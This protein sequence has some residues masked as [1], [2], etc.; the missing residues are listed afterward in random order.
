MVTFISYTAFTFALWVHL[1]TLNKNTFIH[2]VFDFIWRYDQR[3]G[4]I[5]DSAWL[6]DATARQLSPRAVWHHDVLLEAPAWGQTHIWLH[7]ECSGWLLHRYRSTVPTSAIVMTIQT[8]IFKTNTF[9]IGSTLLLKLL[10]TSRFL[11][12]HV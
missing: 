3:R 1:Y 12:I 8:D 10:Q 6:Q 5:I 2:S 9:H 7:T 11:C 4:D